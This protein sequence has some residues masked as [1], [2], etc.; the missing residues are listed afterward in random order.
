MTLSIGK[1]DSSITKGGPATRE[2]KEV[3]RWNATRHGISLPHPGRARSGEERGLG[4]APR[5]R[6]GELLSVRVFRAS[7]GGTGSGQAPSP[8]PLGKD[9]N[10]NPVIPLTYGQRTKETNRRSAST[11]SLAMGQ[12]AT[13]ATHSTH[14]G[15]T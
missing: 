7:A 8:G 10:P 12:D 11:A 1:G 9:A 2:G 5:Q 14:T 4:G 3:V 6:A 13:C 15:S